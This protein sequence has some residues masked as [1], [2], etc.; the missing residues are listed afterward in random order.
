[1][2]TLEKITLKEKFKNG[3]KTTAMNLALVAEMAALGG[4]IMAANIYLNPMKVETEKINGII[5]EITEGDIGY[6][7]YLTPNG[8]IKGAEIPLGLKER[9]S[10]EL[11]IKHK[12][13]PAIIE[14]RTIMYRYRTY[15]DGSPEIY[16]IESYV[17][18][19]K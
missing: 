5:V 4:L 1:M 13:V 14:K 15:P 18:S 8:E 2:K 10:E 12:S 19:L 16:K 17:T 7:R 9:I 3:L 11:L 6:A